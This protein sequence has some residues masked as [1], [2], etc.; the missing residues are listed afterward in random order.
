MSNRTTGRRDQGVGTTA[1]VLF[2]CMMTI[3][4]VRAAEPRIDWRAA[5]I[6]DIAA[7]RATLLEDSPGGEPGVDAAFMSRIDLATA[8]AMA[9][10]KRTSTVEGYHFAL[11]HF[12]DTF[13]DNHLW[14][15]F[16]DP[17]PVRLPGFMIGERA[18]RLEVAVA[19]DPKSGLVG[20][21]L[22]SCEGVPA[23]RMADIVLTAY[24]GQWSAPSSRRHV[25]PLLLA[26][27]GN[28]FIQRPVTCVL[29]KSGRNSTI[30]LAWRTI[31]SAD[32]HRQLMISR[33]IA[34]DPQAGVRPT[35]DG[36]FWIGIP[37]LNALNP[38]AVAGLETLM[39]EIEA[40]G[41]QLRA[42]RYFV[43]DLRGNSG[44]NTFVALRVLN[45]IWGE[46]AVAA[47]R[48]HDLRAEWRAS[49]AN[50]AY[51]KAVQPVLNS[52]FGPHSIASGGLNK[53]LAGMEE[54][55]ARRRPLY[56]DPDEYSILSDWDQGPQLAVAAKP[57]LLTDGG[58]V[59]SC[60]NLVDMVLKLPGVTHIGQETAS[61]TFNLENR[62]QE[63]K[64]GHAT[65]EFPI[66]RYRNRARD[67]Y[68]S[69]RPRFAWTGDMADN[70]ALERWVAELSRRS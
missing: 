28:P 35:A 18:G 55:V 49:A 16:T 60:L 65:L 25:A 1:V 68:E 42:A 36:G 7:A 58:C 8:R 15:D 12:A 29:S 67:R 69:Y 31:G 62:P 53:V 61:D 50:I 19:D 17:I 32:F 20:A 66:K 11:E 64:S 3:A 56:V 44:G 21:R 30:R 14:M 63:L 5:A 23:D 43:I 26:D 39:K 41:P 37:T 52:L 27:L 13:Q 33:G 48:P 47:T 22:V 59:S 45:A 2:I 40:K 34:P 54:S 4:P 38:D 70:A 46:G 9:D 24:A 6:E 10:A 51:L 57:F